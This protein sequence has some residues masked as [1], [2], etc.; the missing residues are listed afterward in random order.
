MFDG[1][2]KAWAESQARLMRNEY[3]AAKAT[4]DGLSR[5]LNDRAYQVFFDA[6]DITL[7][8]IGSFENI[9]L[10]GRNKLMQA[11]RA[12]AKSCRDFDISKSTGL[13][14][15][16]LWLESMSRNSDE[17]KYVHYR[18]GLIIEARRLLQES[19]LKQRKRITDEPPCIYS[20]FGEWYEVFKTAAG[21]MNPQLAQSSDGASLIDFMDD[22]DLRRA[23]AEKSD[24][25]SLARQ[26][27]KEFDFSTFGR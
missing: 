1:V 9:T 6:H 14:L 17:A 26:F 7:S 18:T 23:Y 19:Q 4:V 25:R 3:E 12:D 2:K 5:E 8:Q 21:K 15:F 10:E 16:S 11:F 24:P 20:T 27:A 13:R 22:T